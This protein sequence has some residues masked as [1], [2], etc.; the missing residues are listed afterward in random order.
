MIISASRRTD[1]PAF[2][3]EWLYNRLLSKEVIVRNPMNPNSLTKIYLSP[4]NIDCIVFWTKNPRNFIQYLP[5]IDELGYKYYFQ[6][7]L[8]GYDSSLEP[9]AGNKKEI[10][11]T[12]IELSKL[13]GKEKIIWR[14]DPIIINEKYSI[15]YHIRSF[16]NILDNIYQYTDKCVISFVDSYAFLRNNFIH[17]NINE[18]GDNN[19]I[20]IAK[21]LLNIAKLRSIPIYTCTEKIDLTQ[22]GIYH[23]K[24]ID[25][26]LISKITKSPLNIK[27]DSSQREECK[28]VSS[29]DIGTYNTCT[30]NCVYCYARR[31]TGIYPTTY[32][33][34]SPMLCDKIHGNEKITIIE[35]K[36]NFDS[37]LDL[38]K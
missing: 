15:D 37:Q 25:D 16:E 19:I 21:K 20:K 34:K 31:N 6:F 12:F 18:I 9:N 7:T 22:I 5:K 24:C 11:D 38:F 33:P 35:P 10:I 3:G 30:N 2:F 1:I 17:N 23:N 36:S 28:C 27:K 26:E 8:N 32:D 14:Y 13:I 4:Q 29:R